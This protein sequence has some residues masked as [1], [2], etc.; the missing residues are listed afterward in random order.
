MGTLEEVVDEE[1]LGVFWACG[2]VGLGLVYL[3]IQAYAIGFVD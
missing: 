2:L 1:G 3:A